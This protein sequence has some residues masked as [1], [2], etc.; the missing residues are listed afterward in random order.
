MRILLALILASAALAADPGPLID[1]NTEQHG[2]VLK[3]HTGKVLL[4]NF[5]ATW[6]APCRKEMPLLVE[7]EKK[8]RAK[9]FRMVTVSADEIEDK[10]QALEFLKETGV[11]APAYLKNVDDDDAFIESVDPKWSGALP[12]LYLY[13]RDGKV[14][15]SWVGETE[16]AELEAAI[17][18]LL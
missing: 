9:G 4:V 7:M 1:Y 11:D 3:Q 15:K 5:W 16:I 13:G 8:L 10:A 17:Q 14:A 12:A 18:E 2:K 6:C